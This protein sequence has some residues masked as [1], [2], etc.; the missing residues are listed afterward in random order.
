M[1]SHKLIYINSVDR[2]IGQNINDFVYKVV[3]QELLNKNVY[4]Y[5]VN[6]ISRVCIPAITVENNTFEFTENGVSPTVV[7][8]GTNQSPD[9]FTVA[10]ELQTALNTLSLNGYVYTVT[11]NLNTLHFEITVSSANPISFD[12]NVANSSYKLL[13][14]NEAVHSFVA[15][16]LESVNMMDLGGEYAVYVRIKNGTGDVPADFTDILSQTLCVVPFLSSYGSNLFFHNIDSDYNAKIT[17]F[18]SLE[19]QVTDFYGNLLT[20]NSDF[21]ITLKVEI[22]GENVNDLLK[23]IY[24]SDEVTSGFKSL[25]KQKNAYLFAK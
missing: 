21:V 24:L 11:P 25:Y 14:F 7:T 23:L 3:D 22:I 17:R 19:V 8:L 1:N 10:T 9:C 4:I 2:E 6:F 20:F 16:E 18:N 13:G 5:L 15:Q 12:F